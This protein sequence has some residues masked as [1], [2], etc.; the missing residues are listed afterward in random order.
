MIEVV[1]DMQTFALVF[2][3]KYFLKPLFYCFFKYPSERRRQEIG[4]T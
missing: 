4:Q 3:S 2:N 1:S